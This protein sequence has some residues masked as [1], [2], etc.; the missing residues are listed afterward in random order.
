[1]GMS[2]TTQPKPSL[3]V[4]SARL[5]FHRT[6]PHVTSET[7]LCSCGRVWNRESREDAPSIVA[8]KRPDVIARIVAAVNAIPE[9]VDALDTVTESAINAR[10]ARALVRM[11]QA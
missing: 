5:P 8:V 10:R 11:L 9:P 1:M 6:D 7:A 2:N 3:C 4:C